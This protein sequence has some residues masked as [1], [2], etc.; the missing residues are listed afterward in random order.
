MSVS[1]SRRKCRCCREL[2]AADYRNGSRQHYCSKFECRRASKAASQ[3]AWLS[4]P[5]N[6]NYFRGPDNTRRAQ[7]WRKEHPGYWKRKQPRSGRSQAVGDEPLKPEQ[8][9]CNVP[10]QSSRAL[11]DI[12]LSQDPAF[13]GLISMVTGSTLQEDIVSTARHLV[14][15]GRDILGLGL[16]ETRRHDCQTSSSA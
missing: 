14:A 3:R 6:R 15:K 16:P 10:P 12:C 4:Q 8:T 2:F 1:R 13:I 7:E 5:E 11:Q 9:S